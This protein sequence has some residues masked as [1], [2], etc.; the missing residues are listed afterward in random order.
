MFKYT[1]R[2]YAVALAIASLVIITSLVVLNYS[3]K[4]NLSKTACTTLQEIMEQQSYNFTATLSD[5]KFLIESLAELIAPSGKLEDITPDELNELV[6]KTT[7]EFLGI[8]HPDGKSFNN[9]GT[10][11]YV[12]DRP[13]FQHAMNGDTFISEPFLSRIRPVNV[14]AISAP[15]EN[16]DGIIGVLYGSYTA[17]RLNSL[18]LSSFDKHGYAYITNNEGVIIARTVNGYSL[19]DGNNLFTDWENADFYANDSFEKMKENLYQNK[20]GHSKYML[21]GKKRLVHYATIPI[22]DWNI[23]SIVPDEVISANTNNILTVVYILTIVFALIFTF[24]LVI[25]VDMQRKHVKHLSDIAFVDELTGA[26]T[27]AKFK[28]DAQRMLEEY[29]D[30]KFILIKFDVDR[31]KLINR[32][33]GFATGDMVLKNC[34]NALRDSFEHEKHLF[35][36][37]NID[38]FVLLLEYDAKSDIRK[39]RVEMID[40]FFEYMGSDF[41][42]NIMF[43]AGYYIVREKDWED[44]AAALEKANMAHR[45]AK[46]LQAEYCLYDEQIIKEALDIKEIE[47]RMESALAGGEFK[48]FLQPKRYLADESIAGAEALARWWVNGRF[49]MHPADFVPVFEKNGFVLKLDMFMF[50]EACK[51][52]T[53]MIFEGKKPITVS[54]NF[55][56]MHLSNANFVDD[57]CRIS[58]KHNTPHQYLEIEITETAVFDNEALLTEVLDKLHK[59]GF[60][61][62]MDDFGTG[63]SSLGLLKNIAFDVIKID[64]S[65]FV[66][67]QNPER[68]KTVLLNVIKLAKDLGMHT[69]AEGVENKEHI[70]LL[71]ELGCD[72]VQGY[73]YAKPMPFEEFAQKE[74]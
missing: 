30:T 66:N 12:G 36:R 41:S 35:A 67:A 38:E 18:F 53:N 21:D 20:S 44:I 11:T 24:L 6:G 49:I 31:F 40:R 9:T 37:M 7:F 48:M 23:F 33:Y 71:R 4:N 62:S 15:I 68:S 70:D 22:N 73:Y 45:K 58:D 43:P 55:S 19:T 14:I 13:F 32:I 54:V 46:K 52:V 16:E 27:L 42:Y 57:L 61:L 17:D 25:L 50:E 60:T 2:W 59:A 65:F 1:N 63:Y 72:I 34:V 39:L 56:R 8:A 5:E 74:K 51:F 69:V 64:R 26:P 10:T 47:N 28:M 29:P 3:I